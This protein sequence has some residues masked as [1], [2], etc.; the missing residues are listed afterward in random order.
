MAKTIYDL[1]GKTN[2]F[3]IG[4]ILYENG[5]E[6][7]YEDLE[8]LDEIYIKD[9]KTNEIIIGNL[10]NYDLKFN[11]KLYEII[12]NDSFKSIGNNDYWEEYVSEYI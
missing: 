2:D 12:T 9:L 6:E 5:N 1:G 3:E 8:D 4:Q 10:E 7:F 11:N